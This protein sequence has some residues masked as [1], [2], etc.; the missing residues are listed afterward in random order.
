MKVLPYQKKSLARRSEEKLAP[1]YFGLDKVLEHFGAQWPTRF[2]G[3]ITAQYTLFFVSQLKKELE[4]TYTSQ[5]IPHIISPK[6][7]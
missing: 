7:E 6:L 4:A 1:K 5:P 2:I 3:L